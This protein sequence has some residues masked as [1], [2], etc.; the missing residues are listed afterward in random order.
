MRFIAEEISPETYISL[1][2]QY[3]PAYK[4][5]EFKEINRR[6]TFKEYQEAQ[7]VMEKYGLSNG[8]I[9][10]AHGLEKLAGIHIKP[11]L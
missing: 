5:S 6:I 9:Q 1:M 11:N 10:E 8:W 2:S 4:A 3:L 7:K